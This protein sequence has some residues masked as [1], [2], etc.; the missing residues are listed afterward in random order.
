MELKNETKTN[1]NEQET[2]IKNESS[3]EIED[4]TLTFEDLKKL[5]KQWQRENNPYHLKT[6]SLTELMD[7][8]YQG[9]QPIIDNLL[10]KGTYLFVGA[11]KMGK[12]F[13]MVQLAFHISNGLTLWDLKCRKGTVLYLALEDDYRRLQSRIYRMFQSDCNDNLHFCVS[14]GQLGK[15]L[16]EQ[17]ENFIKEHPDTSLIIIDTLQKIRELGDN[18]Y[19]YSSDYEIIN[20]LKSF[21]DNHS[22]CMLLVHHTRKQNADDKFDMISGTNGLLGAAD[23]AFILTKEKRTSDRATLDVVGRDQQEQRFHLTRNE[24][25]LAWDLENVERE[26]WKEPP[27][28]LLDDIVSLVNEKNKMWSGSPT[29]LATAIKADIKPHALTPKLNI[30]ADRLLKEH[31]IYYTRKRSHEGRIIQLIYDAS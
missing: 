3:N 13:M 17:L 1:L 29:E 20:R 18:R 2:E 12:S 8:V 11:P 5:Q 10:Y 30:L 31:N 27:E 7:N 9:S 6:L 23:G 22:I 16:D 4:V 25:T 19:S 14:A 26:M 15:G 21:A 24:E 28:P